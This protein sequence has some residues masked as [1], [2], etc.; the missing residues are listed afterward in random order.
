MNQQT[1]PIWIIVFAILM[2]CVAIRVKGSE[3]IGSE[4][5]GRNV[6]A[7]R[8]D[9]VES[10][11]E[12]P[13]ILPAPDTA[14]LAEQMSKPA[15]MRRHQVAGRLQIGD[16]VY[17]LPRAPS[18]R[19][20]PRKSVKVRAASFHANLVNW[21]ADAETDGWI[22]EVALLDEQGDTVLMGKQHPVEMPGDITARFSLMP[23]RPALDFDGYVDAA[24]Q[25]F[26][27][28][29]TLRFSSPGIARVRLPL[30]AVEL[31]EL[32]GSTVERRLVA[33]GGKIR[34]G[35]ILGG[36]TLPAVGR[37]TMRVIVPS[38]GAFDSVAQV[39]LRTPFLVDTSW[40]YQ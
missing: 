20:A 13:S 17:E 1:R 26:V 2:A 28:T 32:A 23:V 21:D 33:R 6:V 14:A 16:R 15:D 36:S 19:T 29:R 37:L 25:P 22:V 39:D 40:P 34:G 31:Q 3:V 24:D 18:A 30:E 4:V 11:A 7:Q 12:G 9:Q 38:Q 35:A 8:I 10:S 5:D 27:W